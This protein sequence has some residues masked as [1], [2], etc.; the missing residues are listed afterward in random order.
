MA[1]LAEDTFER[2]VEV[3]RS[4]STKWGVRASASYYNQV[5]ARDSFISFIG[6][7]MLEDVSLLSTSRRTIDTL[8]KTRSPLGQI[9]DFYNPDEERAE[10][11]FSGAT[12]A[13]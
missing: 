12:D 8:A 3:L 10:F 9:A 1:K 13:S 5:W 2:A 4:N 7:N 11:G 6:S